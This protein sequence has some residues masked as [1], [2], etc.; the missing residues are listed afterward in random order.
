MARGNGQLAASSF[1]TQPEMAHLSYTTGVS[2][3][4]LCAGG[5]ALQKG[6]VQD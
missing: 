5:Q 1:K 6:G 2:V 4:A 3:R